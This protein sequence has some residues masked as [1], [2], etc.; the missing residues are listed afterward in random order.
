M[1][2]ILM[3]LLFGAVTYAYESARDRHWMRLGVGVVLLAGWCWLAW[4]AEVHYLGPSRRE[5]FGCLT[6]PFR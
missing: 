4:T 1:A 2:I 5:F 3:F 6:R